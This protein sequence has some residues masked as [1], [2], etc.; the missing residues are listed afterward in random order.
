MTKTG[1]QSSSAPPIVEEKKRKKTTSKSTED[2]KGRSFKEEGEADE[3][4]TEP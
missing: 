2:G 1:T 3:A 4:C